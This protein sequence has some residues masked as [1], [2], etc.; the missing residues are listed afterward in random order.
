MKSLIQIS[1]A[2]LGK[3]RKDKNKKEGGLLCRYR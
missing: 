1:R 3:L 2:Q